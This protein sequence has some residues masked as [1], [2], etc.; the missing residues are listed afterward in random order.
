MA[1]ATPNRPGQ[2]N[3]AGDPKALFLRLFAGEVLTAFD[4]ASAFRQ[5]HR[6]RVIPHGKSASFPVTGLASGY[7]HTPGEEILGQNIRHGERIIDVEDLLI[8]PVFIANIDEAM[9]HFDVRSI[10]SNEVGQALGKSYDQAVAATGINAARAASVIDDVVG[11]YTDN[12]ADYDTDG[13]KLW[14]GIFDTGIVFDERDIPTDG[15]NAF[16]RPVQ[17]ALV[18]KSEKPINR[19]INAGPNGGLDTG[20]V[21]RIN[22]IPLVK[23]NNLPGAN[24]TARTEI[25]SIR[26]KDYSPTQVLV[27]HESAVGTVQLQD[28]T[29]ES[30]YDMRRQGTLMIGKYLVGHGELRPEAAAELRTADP[31]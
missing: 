6:V 4:R 10:Y 31:A 8:A 1:N 26:R 19:D 23:T 14:Q 16:I 12:D 17:Y 20:M 5:R 9:Q 24:W 22:S 13:T 29:M 15:R 18:V 11:G 28:V 3:L 27:Q 25:P 21:Y 30:G 2:A 7:Y